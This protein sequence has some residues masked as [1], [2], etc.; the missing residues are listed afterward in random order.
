V[1]ARARQA[2]VQMPIAEAVVAVLDGSASPTQAL[3]RLLA[4]D[5]KPESELQ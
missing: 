2:R 3:E 4:R 1:L 5:P